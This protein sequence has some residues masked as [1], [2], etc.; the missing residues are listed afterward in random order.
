MAMDAEQDSGA[1]ERGHWRVGGT[2]R[3]QEYREGQAADTRRTIL[4]NL[5]KG[6]RPLRLAARVPPLVI[7]GLV[8]LQFN[9]YFRRAVA[10]RHGAAPR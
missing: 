8:I 7:Y 9:R 1:Q 10:A 4:T 5:Y 3:Q 2:Y 6:G